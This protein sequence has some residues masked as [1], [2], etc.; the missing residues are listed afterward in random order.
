M[1]A[2]GDRASLDQLR[3]AVAEGVAESSLRQVARAV[4]MS[5]TGLQKFLHGATP[6]TATRRKLE[7]WYVREPQRYGGELGAGSALAAMRVLV[8]AV[9]AGQRR[10]VTV[11]VVRLLEGAYRAA[12]KPVPAWLRD[13]SAEVRR[14][15]GHPP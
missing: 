12:G 15:A 5:P 4:G 10:R 3:E 11:D 6:Y 13:V 7:H 14:E 9:P 2:R 1:P 8:A